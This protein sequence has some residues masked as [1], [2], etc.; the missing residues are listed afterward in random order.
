MELADSEIVVSRGALL[1]DIVARHLAQTVHSQELFVILTNELIQIAE[2]ALVMRDL[3][4]LEEVGTILMSLPMEAAQQ[5]GLYYHAFAINRSR[6]DQAE[7]LLQTVADNGPITYRARAIQTL[8]GIHEL[9]GELDEALRFQLEALRAASDKNAHGLQTTLMAHHEIS[10]IKSLDGDHKGALSSFRSFGPLVNL[11]AKQEPLYFYVYCSELAIELGELGHLVEAEATLEVALASP[12][13]SAYP[14]WSE[15]RQELDAK[16]TAATPSVVA[17]NRTPEAPPSPQAE[18]QPKPRRSTA[19]LSKWLASE[20]TFL[21][22]PSI[23]T[24]AITIIA[25]DQITQITLDRVLVCHR[26]R[27][28]P[29]AHR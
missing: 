5:V 25:S 3:H 19:R 7:R 22:R 21:Q 6:R 1:R 10:V 29:T 24:A 13:A 11:V 17:I 9:S 28:P 12:Y 2:Q 20:N 18:P 16:R 23:P 4:A 27:A 15:T 26:S 8:G 14:E